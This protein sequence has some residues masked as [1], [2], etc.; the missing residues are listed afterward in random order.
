ML[1]LA[2]Y[3]AIMTFP[4]QQPTAQQPVVEYAFKQDLTRRVGVYRGT[5]IYPGTLDEHGNFIPDKDCKSFRNP[6]LPIGGDDHVQDKLKF[7]RYI[8]INL[9]KEVNESVYEYRSGILIFGSLDD[10]GNFIPM[11]GER[12]ILFLNYTGERTK[13]RIYN[14]PGDFVPKAKIP[15]EKKP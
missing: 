3:L 2:L 15:H 9:Q 4:F 6:L 7:N 12:P 1:R 14:L 5:Q 8:V 13:H 10:D 11:L